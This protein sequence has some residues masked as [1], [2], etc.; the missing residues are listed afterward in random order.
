MGVEEVE[1]RLKNNLR[2]FKFRKQLGVPIVQKAWRR[3]TEGQVGG[4]WRILLWSGSMIDTCQK[5]GH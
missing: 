5:S 1:M 2:I 3:Q 4:E